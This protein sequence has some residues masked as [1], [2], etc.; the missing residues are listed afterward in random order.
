MF[1]FIGRVVS[2][3]VSVDMGRLCYAQNFECVPQVV[4]FDMS[5]SKER[6]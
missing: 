6:F 4:C 1:V 5:V 3:W 2:V